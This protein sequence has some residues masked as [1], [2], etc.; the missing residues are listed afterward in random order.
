MALFAALLLLTFFLSLI[1][2]GILSA[3]ATASKQLVIVLLIQRLRTLNLVVGNFSSSFLLELNEYYAQCAS[4]LCLL[5]K[6]AFD[7][8]S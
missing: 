3:H 4:V 7:T 8:S 1:R 6:A 2:S 5:L